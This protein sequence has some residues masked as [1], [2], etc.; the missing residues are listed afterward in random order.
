MAHET[1]PGPPPRARLEGGGP[2][3]ERGRLEAS[4]LLINTPECLISEGL[5]ELGRPFVVPPETELELLVELSSGPGSAIAAD[6]PSARRSLAG[7]RHRDPRR[8]PAELRPA[9][10]NAAL[11]RHVDGADR[12]TVIRWLETVALMTPERA[13][14]QAEFLEHPT[15]R[16]YVFVYSEGAELLERWLAAVPPADRP[17]R[18]GRLLVEPLTPSAIVRELAAG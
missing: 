12:P 11:M 2:V 18:F 10:V 3:E 4:V 1:Y 7:A 9:A 5:A 13:A 17:A 16:T 8:P 6:D 14:Q 15:W